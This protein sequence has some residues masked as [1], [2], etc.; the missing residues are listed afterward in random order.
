MLACRQGSTNSK[1]SAAQAVRQIWLALPWCQSQRWMKREKKPFLTLMM[2]I[3]H[4]KPR[5]AHQHRCRQGAPYQ[6]SHREQRQNGSAG[7]AQLRQR[8]VQKGGDAV[9]LRRDQSPQAGMWRATYSLSGETDVF[10]PFNS[11]WARVREL[12]KVDRPRPSC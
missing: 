10:R 4:F 8:I 2:R 11:K 9:I 12:R 6:N 5:G 3:G 1:P 7:S